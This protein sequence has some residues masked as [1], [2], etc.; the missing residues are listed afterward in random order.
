DVPG[1]KRM[2]GAGPEAWGIGEAERAVVRQSGSNERREVRVRV[3]A[4]VVVAVPAHGACE[5]LEKLL[6]GGQVCAGVGGGVAAV[7][8][9]LGPAG[10]KRLD[11]A[12]AEP[13]VRL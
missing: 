1:P 10:R 8:A 11:E 13:V 12:R 4:Q 3:D 2:G 5:R 7:K 6:L 9:D